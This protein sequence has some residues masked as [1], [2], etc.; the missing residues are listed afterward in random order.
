MTEA[1]LDRH[2]AELERFFL[3]ALQQG[4]DRELMEEFAQAAEQDFQSRQAVLRTGGGLG[5]SA[6]DLQKARQVTR[7]QYAGRQRDRFVLRY[8]SRALAGLG[9]VGG[10]RSRATLEA[11][12]RDSKS[13]LQ[14]TAREALQR[15]GGKRAPAPR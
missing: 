9:V 11:V 14:N 2:Q 10:E 15:L 6:T 4:P 7:T 3:Y 8:K 5:L 1:A 13:P 12:A